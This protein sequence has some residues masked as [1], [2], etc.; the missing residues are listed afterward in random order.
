[1]ELSGVVSRTWIM[2]V[3]N[4][5]EFTMADGFINPHITED[6]SSLPEVIMGFAITILMLY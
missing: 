6:T 3:S 4:S 2:P 5:Y 1:M